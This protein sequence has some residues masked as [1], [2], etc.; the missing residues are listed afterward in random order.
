MKLKASKE[1]T[2]KWQIQKSETNK[3]V[4][5]ALFFKLQ[6]AGINCEKLYVRLNSFQK[7]LFQSISIFFRFAHPWNLLFLMCY[8]NLPL[9][10]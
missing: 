10:F 3:Y 9:M 6:A 7:P 1:I 2:C 8:F 5:R 4:S